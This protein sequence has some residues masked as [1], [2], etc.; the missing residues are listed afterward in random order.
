M[1]GPLDKLLQ[2]VLPKG[3]GKKTGTGITGT[4]RPSSA[5]QVLPLP[6][7]R[8]HLV[9][10]F[11]DRYSNDSRALIKKLFKQDPDVS[12]AVNAYLTI[13]NQ[14]LIMVAR[15]QEGNIDHEGMKMLKQLVMLLTRRWDYSTGFR[16]KPS[17]DTLVDEMRYMLLMR[18][19]I[20][21]ELVFDERLAPS[22]LRHIDL[23]S[24]RW[25]ERKAGEYKPV[26][27][28]DGAEVKLDVPSV[29]VAFFHR[30]PT[31]IYADSSFTAAINTIAARQ[32]VV[33]DLYRIM[34][35]T[36]YPRMDVK[37]L[38]EVI[39]KN[40]PANVKQDATKLRQYLNDRLAEIRTAVTQ[41]RP[42]QAFVH[43]DSVEVGIVN[44][45]NPG[46]GI[47]IKPVIDVL[48]GQ[49]QAALKTMATII[50]RGES[51]VNTA[52]V[53]ARVF[54]LNCDELNRPIAEL[55]QQ[56]FTF[57]MRLQGFEGWVE[58]EFKKA[59]MRAD[60]ELEPQRSMQQSRL[61]TDLSHGIISDDEYHLAM[62]G[63]IRPDSAPELSGTGFM[64]PQ[65]VGVDETKV[66][67]NSDPLGR[68]LASKGGNQAKSNTNK[69]KPTS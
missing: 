21:A 65:P 31:S 37:I 25:Y 42:D 1:A 26:Q 16:Y 36:G 15:D 47:D 39:L 38:E 5:D 12:A 69:V 40:A 35:V 66:S 58:C 6:Q 51:G 46:M 22:E 2:V 56:M 11:T 68:S 67:P 53:E 49:N 18:G 32:Q 30:D 27:D 34:Q 20:M 23:A 33:N 59:E 50:G 63:R 52:S 29:F 14:E 54:A 60:L 9:D 3:K 44:D 48:N 19:G 10:I 61:L 55:L 8:D 41:I 64:N 24:I 45:K 28:Q 62:Y 17:L 43:Y 4:F 13:A 57:A 7:Y